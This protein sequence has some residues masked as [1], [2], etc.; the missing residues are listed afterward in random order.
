M[1]E[2]IDA[3]VASLPADPSRPWAGTRAVGAPRAQ[4]TVARYGRL[5]VGAVVLGAILVGA[6]FLVRFGSDALIHADGLASRWFVVQRTDTWDAITLVGS[7]LAK[8]VTV[9]GVASVMFVTLRIWLRR[10]DESIMLATALGGELLIFLTVTAIVKRPR[11]PVFRL[12][13]APPT[14]SFPSGHTAAAVVAYVFI[15][16]ILWRYLANRYVA[17]VACVLLSAVPIAVAVARMYRGA[18]FPTDVIGGALLGIVWLTFVI[19]TLVPKGQP[20]RV[21]SSGDDVRVS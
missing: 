7:D 12:D 19:R 17:T 20:E 13:E 1:S 5:A 9:V 8:T 4:L 3:P 21:S 16:Y 15:A 10:W 6:G 11:P 18:H 2:P 14:S